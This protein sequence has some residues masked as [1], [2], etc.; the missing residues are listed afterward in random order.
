M[1]LVREV[2]GQFIFFASKV[3][4]WRLFTQP[5]GIGSWELILWLLKSLKNRG[6]GVSYFTSMGRVGGEVD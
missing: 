4:K 2:T 5:G 3:K 6:S 1:T